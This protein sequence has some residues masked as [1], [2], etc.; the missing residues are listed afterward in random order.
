[1]A[2]PSIS[3]F[4]APGGTSP[5]F[6]AAATAAHADVPE[7]L[8]RPT[9]RSQMRIDTSRPSD[10]W[11][12]LDVRTLREGC[13]RTDERARSG[14]PRRGSTRPE[15]PP[16]AGCPPTPA[17]LRFARGLPPA[18]ARSPA[19]PDRPRRPAPAR[20]RAGRPG[21]PP[22]PSPPARPRCRGARGA[23]RTAA[24]APRR[25]TPENHPSGAFPRRRRYTPATRSPFPLRSNSPPSGLNMRNRVSAPGAP[26]STTTIPSPPGPRCRSQIRRTSPGVSTGP[27]PSSK[28][29]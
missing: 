19:R 6:T 29:R 15:T 3:T 27:S 4:A 28:T 13:M 14:P 11:A 17:R 2:P 16:R 9:P 12:K 18:D 7:A 23:P 10:A 1:M 25:P 8:V 21:T 22:F 5:Y 24:S 26:A 20:R